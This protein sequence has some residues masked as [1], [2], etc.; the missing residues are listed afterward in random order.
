MSHIY[1]TCSHSLSF[2]PAQW[3]TWSAV[4]C[5]CSWP[6]WPLQQFMWC[7]WIVISVRSQITKKIE[8]DCLKALPR[9]INISSQY[10]Q[11]ALRNSSL[12]PWKPRRDASSETSEREGTRPT[13]NKLKRIKRYGLSG[14]GQKVRH[15]TLDQTPGLSFLE[16]IFQ[17]LSE[18]AKKKQ[19]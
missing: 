16:Q 14:S 10:S 4:Q 13:E 3:G 1:C 11:L 5:W 12:S 8:G 7:V 17:T 6:L 19:R 18:L 15:S 9:P 2:N